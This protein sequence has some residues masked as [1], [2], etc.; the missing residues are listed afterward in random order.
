MDCSSQIT[1]SFFAG[2]AFLDF[3][4]KENE[5]EKEKEK[6]KNK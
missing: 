1:E 6:E 3:S 2:T 4:Q 5:N